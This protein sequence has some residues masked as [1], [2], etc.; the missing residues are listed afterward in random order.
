MSTLCQGSQAL[1]LISIDFE[2]M[3][4]D[5]KG[6]NEA[7]ISFNELAK[8][9]Q[10]QQLSQWADMVETTAKEL[11]GDTMG[12]I[13]LRG[14]GNKLYLRYKEHK[15]KICLIQAI[16]SH[17]HSMPIPLQGVFIKLATDLKTGSS[18]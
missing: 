7:I 10:P 14:Q 13:E 1:N 8:S 5:N 17:V 4:I 6:I 18:N 15:S 2:F 11:C 3:G 16:D 12:D 9:I